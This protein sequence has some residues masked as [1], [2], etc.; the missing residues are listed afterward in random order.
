MLLETP[1]SILASEEKSE[2]FEKHRCLQVLEVM[3]R[4]RFADEKMQKL[5]RQ[6]KGGTFH[7]C[8]NGHELVGALSAVALTPFKDWGL[9]YY[10]DRAFAL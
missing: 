4:T 2:L 8:V 1:H 10:R 6:N 5:I 3:H 9:P 7:L